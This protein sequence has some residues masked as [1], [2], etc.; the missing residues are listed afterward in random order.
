MTF[1]NSVVQG[2]VT[3]IVSGIQWAS[4]LKEQLHHRSRPYGGSPMNGVLPTAVAN[5]GGCGGAALD[6]ESSHVKILLG[7][8]KVKG[9]LHDP[10]SQ[11]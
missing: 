4:V 6:E 1:S 7:G 11:S 8:Y 2:C 5:S 9:R 10:Q 3:L